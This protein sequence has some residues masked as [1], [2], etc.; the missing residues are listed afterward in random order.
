MAVEQ[1]VFLL[2]APDGVPTG[3]VPPNQP[4]KPTVTWLPK[5]A[6]Q[7]ITLEGAF[8]IVVDGVKYQAEGYDDIPGMGLM[9]MPDGTIKAIF[10]FEF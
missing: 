8:F 10:P 7:F 2:R 4:D 5:G 6:G 3:G 9:Q 1:K